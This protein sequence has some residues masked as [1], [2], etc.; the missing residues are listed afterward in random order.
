VK[1]ILLIVSRTER[2]LPNPNDATEGPYE[3]RLPDLPVSV[4]GHDIPVIAK[5]SRSSAQ[6]ERDDRAPRQHVPG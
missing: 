3:A 6:P 5:E 1:I 4:F 2:F